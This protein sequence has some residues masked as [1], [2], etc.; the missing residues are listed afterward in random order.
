MPRYAADPKWIT[1]KF[2]GK[3]HATTCH[4]LIRKGERIFYYPSSKSARC[5]ACG[6]AASR[7]FD[8]A[9]AD[10]EFMNSMFRTA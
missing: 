1:A 5:Q 9:K 3:C 4:A 2:S 7:E 10:E 8:A 6:E